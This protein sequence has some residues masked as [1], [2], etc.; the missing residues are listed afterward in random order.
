MWAN[1]RNLRISFFLRCEI[2]F[3]SVLPF[4]KKKKKAPSSSKILVFC[5]SCCQQFGKGKSLNVLACSHTW[6][7]WNIYMAAM[8]SSLVMDKVLSVFSKVLYFGGQKTPADEQ[9]NCSPSTSTKDKNSNPQ[10][11]SPQRC[12]LCSDSSSTCSSKQLDLLK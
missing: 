1:C 7:E 9:L 12:N 10:H 2:S 6:A 8:L 11:S 4:K 3:A 5:I